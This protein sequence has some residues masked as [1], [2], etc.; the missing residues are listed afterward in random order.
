MKSILFASSNQGK[1]KEVSKIF[2]SLNI[3]VLSMTDVFAENIDVPEKGKTFEENAQIKAKTIGQLS[4]MITLADDSGLEIEAL[5]GEPGVYSARYA[6]TDEKRIKKVLKKL[7]N[8]RNRKARFYCAISV[9]DPDSGELKTYNGIVNGS[10]TQEQEGK[11]GFG[12]DPIFYSAEL[13]KT[14]SQATMEE[15]NQISHRKRALVN[16]SSWV[17]R[18]AK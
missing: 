4:G 8:N 17:I 16:A 18:L 6:G 15:K 11:G 2:A 9:Y 14:F 5:N 7:K 13:G 12:Y 10:I 3:K 1:I